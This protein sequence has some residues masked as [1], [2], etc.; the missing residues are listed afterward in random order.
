MFRAPEAYIKQGSETCRKAK[1]FSRFRSRRKAV[2]K[3][4][5]SVFPAHRQLKIG[6]LAEILGDVASY[7]DLTRE[8]LTQQL[9]G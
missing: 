9:F 1:S 8:E 2:L 3:L 4:A 5:L 7:L 6:T